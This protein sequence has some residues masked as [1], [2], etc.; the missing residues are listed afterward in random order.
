MP[1]PATLSRTAGIILSWQ[2]TDST[3]PLTVRLNDRRSGSLV[4]WASNRYIVRIGATSGVT[5]FAEPVAAGTNFLCTGAPPSG[6]IPAQGAAYLCK[7]CVGWWQKRP[8]A[9][10]RDS[11]R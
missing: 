8:T 6:I 4:S 2:V 1:A 9:K 5:S 10:Y 7:T 11:S 3:L